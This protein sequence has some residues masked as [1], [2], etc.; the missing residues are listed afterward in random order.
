MLK[1]E[2]KHE[3]REGKWLS[4]LSSSAKHRQLAKIN[5]WLNGS[6]EES[7]WRHQIEEATSAHISD[8]ISQKSAQ[9]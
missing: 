8:N 3:N 1:S 6:A 7:R 9:K 5:R 2:G 4:A